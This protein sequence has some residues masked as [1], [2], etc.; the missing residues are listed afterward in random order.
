MP[1]VMHISPTCTTGVL[2]FEIEGGD[3]KQRHARVPVH[4]G[5][6]SLRL[7][8]LH[9]LSKGYTCKIGRRRVRLCS[10]VSPSRGKQIPPQTVVWYSLVSGKHPLARSIYTWMIEQGFRAPGMTGSALT[11]PPSSTPHRTAHHT[12]LVATCTHSV[13][14]PQ[15]RE[16]SS[17]QKPHT[18]KNS[19]SKSFRSK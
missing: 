3:A 16:A 11:S 7:R 12:P 10:Q 5:S 6:C 2:D 8:R 18:D 9:P 1:T 17:A 13:S 14:L 19:I 15:W 4:R